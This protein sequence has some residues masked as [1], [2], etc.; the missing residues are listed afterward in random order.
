[1]ILS[2]K[3]RHVISDSLNYAFT[4]RIGSVDHVIWRNSDRDTWHGKTALTVPFSADDGG[5][6]EPIAEAPRAAKKNC[7]SATFIFVF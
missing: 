1:M 3:K 6:Y 7:A 4:F 5:F 2:H